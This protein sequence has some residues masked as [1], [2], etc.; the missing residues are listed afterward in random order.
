MALFEVG[1]AY[2]QIMTVDNGVVMSGFE[3][4]CHVHHCILCHNIGLL[5]FQS[6]AVHTTVLSPLFTALQSLLTNAGSTPSPDCG[7]WQAVR[8][9]CSYRC[10]EAVRSGHLKVLQ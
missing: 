6:T 9:E 10:Y 1:I 5:V 7:A 3:L 4:G 8:L 2:T